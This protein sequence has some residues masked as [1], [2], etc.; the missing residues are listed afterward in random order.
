[1]GN[2][3]LPKGSIIYQTDTPV[4]HIACII[5]G[6]VTAS[7]DFE[8]MTLRAGDVMG[9]TDLC[10]HIHS[11]TY[12]AKEDCLIVSYA[13]KG[14]NTIEKLLTENATLAKCALGSC[15]RQAY[16]LLDS[17]LFRQYDCQ[18]L[19]T[20]LN[21]S[22]DEYKTLCQALL[23]SPKAI[24][25]SAEDEASEEIPAFDE[26]SVIAQWMRRYYEDLQSM[27]EDRATDGFVRHPAFLAGLILKTS[28]DISDIL[29][30]LRRTQEYQTELSTLL[31]NENHFDFYDLFTGLS[32]HCL[33][34]G[35]ENLSLTATISTLENQILSN[36]SIDKTMA[37]KRLAAYRDKIAK[38]MAKKQSIATTVDTATQ[39]RDTLQ[40]SLD[41]ILKY[42]GCSPE[43]AIAFKQLVSDYKHVIDKNS[44]SND[45]KKLRLELTT[46]FYEIYLAAFKKSISDVQTPVVLKMFFLFG[47]VDEQLAGEEN[48]EYLC[49]IADTYKG[50]PGRG[51]YTIY[52]WLTSIYMGKKEPRRNEYDVDYQS[53]VHEQFINKKID[54]NQE[55]ELLE[56]QEQKLL[57]EINN[58]FSSTNKMTYGRVTTFCPVF[59]EHNVLTDLE[60]ALLHPDQLL[61]SVNMIRSIDFSAF[62]REELF[63]E[64]SSNL[65]EQIQREILPDIILMPNVGTRGVMW[66]E[67]EGKRRLSPATYVLPVFLQENLEQTIVRLTG[68]YRFEICKRTQGARWNDV[69]EPSLTSEY[70]DYVQF[71]RKNNDLSTDAKD[72]IKVALAKARNSFKQMFVQDYLI[73]ILF[74]GKGA[75][76]LNKIARRI[77]FLYCPFSKDIRMT[78]SSNPL[79]KDCMERWSIRRGQQKTR[80]E[81]LLKKLQNAGK[82]IPD[83]LLLQQ[84]FLEM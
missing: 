78:L 16:A 14:E 50:D 9:I 62:Y 28:N 58:F 35:E 5:K 23:V 68:E 76:R 48:A 33:K 30:E 54:K 7:C 1:M 83:E 51:I 43:T 66:Q 71:Y 82:E 34:I 39:Y 42:A 26:D 8:E 73:W 59:S 44:S 15:I 22:Y 69:S 12:Q 81:N 4:T 17:Y 37:E 53:Y 47:Y 46:R 32:Y 20:F 11:F 18:N 74:E 24:P 6:S 75:P 77:L 45:F 25:L 63:Y 52:E 13:L 36:S 70:C 80:F 41:K 31:L 38:T 55:K 84:A 57:F 72:K 3:S 29:G 27:Q 60:D 10:R 56:D 19:Y 49:S 79:Y 21:S 65:R 61:S 64:S 2:L 40:N 67:I